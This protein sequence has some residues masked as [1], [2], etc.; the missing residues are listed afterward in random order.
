MADQDGSASAADA[1]PQN[2]YSMPMSINVAD[3]AE[4]EEEED[5]DEY[6]Y[7]YSTTEKEAIILMSSGLL[8]ILT[9][10]I[11]ILCN[12]RFDESKRAYQKKVGE[13]AS[14]SQC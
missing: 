5:E 12:S 6:E 2:P 3:I 13:N 10:A 8:S 4:E 11:D 14:A 7:E 9:C 1:P